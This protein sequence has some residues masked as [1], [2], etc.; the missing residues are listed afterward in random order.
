MTATGNYDI[1]PDA[2]LIHCGGIWT[3]ANPAAAAMLGYDDPSELVGRPIVESVPVED[4][5]L[6]LRRA[7]DAARGRRNPVLRQRLIRRDGTVIDVEIAGQPV[8]Q[9]AGG[10]AVLIVVRDVSDRIAEERRFQ[11]TFEQAA[12]GIAHIAL[13][14]SWLRV[15]RRFAEIVGHD[16]EELLR[17]TFRDIT[18]PEDRAADERQA[19]ALVEGAIE[20]ISMNKRCLRAD[21][22]VIWIHLTASIVR[23]TDG[24]PDYFM[25]V[26]EDISAQRAAEEKLQASEERF[27]HLVEHGAELIAVLTADVRFHYVSPTIEG[28]LGYV[29]ADLVGRSAA[30][31]VHPDDRGGMLKRLQRLVSEPRATERS[32][33]RV[34]ATNGEWRT[35][36]I[37]SRNLID[38]PSVG[39]IVLNAQDRTEPLRLI[40]ELAQLRRVESLGRVAASVAHEFNNALAA[41]TVFAEVLEKKAPEHG[42]VVRSIKDALRRGKY[43]AEEILRYGQP[44][45]VTKQPFDVGEWLRELQNELQTQLAARHRLLLEVEENLPPLSADRAQLSQVITNLVLNARDASPPGAPITIAAGRAR[46]EGL[47]LEVRDEGTGIEPHALERLFEPMFTTKKSGTGLGLPI[48]QQIVLRHGGRVSVESAVGRGSRFTIVMP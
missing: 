12:V 38:D 26:A 17:R 23:R 11:N 15:N 36:A 45:K 48:V 39:G 28:V 3:Y 22:A 1:F 31:L 6:V 19:A 7:N 27:R 41:A 18:H 13:D 21:E 30:E 24:T 16:Y 32:T 33:M 35:L 2:V 29:P 37:Y 25:V 34:R 46:E 42:Q 4:R 9:T 8:A 20:K 14:G 5:A 40:D 43:I 47:A 10:A 44:A